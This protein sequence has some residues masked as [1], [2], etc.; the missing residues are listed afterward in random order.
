MDKLQFLVFIIVDAA[1]VVAVVV[2]IIIVFN[3]P[4]SIDPRE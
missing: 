2:V 3:T 1:V 4:G